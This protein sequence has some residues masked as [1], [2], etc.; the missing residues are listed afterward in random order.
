MN[1]MKPIRKVMTAPPSTEAKIV[2]VGFAHKALVDRLSPGGRYIDV[3]DDV[4]SPWVPFGDKAAIKHL[5]FDV[6]QNLFSNILWVKGPGVVGTHLHRGT[7]TMVCLE[8]SV[9]YLEYDWVASP[10][11][12]ILEYP[13]KATPWSPT[14]PTA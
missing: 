10:G 14:T 4:D 1:D 8:G 12:L 7:I 5:A 6:R 13:A 9:K 2:D 11:G 3:P